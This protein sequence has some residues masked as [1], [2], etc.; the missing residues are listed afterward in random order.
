MLI[1]FLVL[2]G[3]FIFFLGTSLFNSFK[4]YTLLDE[5]N[6]TLVLSKA[7][8][9]KIFNVPIK[10]VSITLS[11]SCKDALTEGSAQQSIIKSKFWEFI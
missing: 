4:E 10:L 2:R 3:L 11:N 1:F 6:I 8:F 7:H 5:R 9:L